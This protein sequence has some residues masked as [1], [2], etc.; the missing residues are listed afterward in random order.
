MHWK[1][2]PHLALGLFLPALLLGQKPSRAAEP[3]PARL[4][5]GARRVYR[6]SYTNA[7]ESDLRALFAGR[8]GNSP[9]RAPSGRQNPPSTGLTHALRTTVEGD[10][11]TTV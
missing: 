1:F 10:W 2:S 5:A 7:S 9:S 6:L 8:S 4:V 3:A 11:V